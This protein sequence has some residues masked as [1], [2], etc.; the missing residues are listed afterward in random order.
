M[1]MDTTADGTA[2]AAGSDQP[3][4]NPMGGRSRASVL[5]PSPEVA[6]ATYP[7][8]APDV[9]GDRAVFLKDGRGMR[10][11]FLRDIIYL[12]ADGNYVELHLRNGRVVLRN[13][14][15]EVLKALPPDVF[16]MVNRAQAVNI[17]LV[18]YV[19]SD[20][21][22]I[23]KFQFTLSRRYRDELVSRLPVITGR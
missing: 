8:T 12:E 17:L 19:S 2:G 1:R 5:R 7:L 6:F 3:G 22:G 10:R 18:D 21:V 16:Y 15:A 11:V 13:S 23:G 4:P 20:E 9:V 14:M